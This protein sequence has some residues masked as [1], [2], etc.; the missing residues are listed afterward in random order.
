MVILLQSPTPKNQA[1]SISVHFDIGAQKRNPLPLT[2]NHQEPVTMM[3][4]RLWMKL[5][6]LFAGNE[7]VRDVSIAVQ[8]PRF[9]PTHGMK[10]LNGVVNC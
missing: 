10:M 3:L 5:F 6:V 4:Q 8:K 1:P 2:K 7:S 9:G